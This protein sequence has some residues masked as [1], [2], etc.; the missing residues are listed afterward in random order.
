MYVNCALLM[1]FPPADE[2]RCE[3][4]SRHVVERFPAAV[5][6]NRRPA[7]DRPTVVELPIERAHSTRHASTPV[8][9]GVLDGHALQNLRGPEEVVES[10][11]QPEPVEHVLHDRRIANPTTLMML[12]DR[13]GYVAVALMGKR[14]NRLRFGERLEAEFAVDAVFAGA[15][16]LERLSAV[17]H[18]AGHRHRSLLTD[19]E[20]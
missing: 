19:S 7:C 13:R 20:L 14:V 4:I 8:L 16:P 18:A 12:H 17:L 9:T 10:L 6:V 5:E 11:G 15:I 1:V 3:E 2:H